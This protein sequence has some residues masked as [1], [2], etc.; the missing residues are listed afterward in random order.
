MID[1]EALTAELRAAGFQVE[2]EVDPYVNERRVRCCGWVVSPAGHVWRNGAE[3]LVDFQSLDIIRRHIA[4]PAEHAA[5]GSDLERCVRAVYDGVR[6]YERDPE[7]DDGISPIDF[8]SRLGFCLSEL[9]PPATGSADR[10]V[11]RELLGHI[12][13]Y[14]LG[15]K[16]SG[17]MED[18]ERWLL[19][20]IDGVLDDTWRDAT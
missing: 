4:P 1:Q 17:E 6:A 12:R 11:V 14:F 8:G 3:G 19:N 7:S 15:L 9:Q 16:T 20:R 10:E 18:E 2:D 5:T 13:L